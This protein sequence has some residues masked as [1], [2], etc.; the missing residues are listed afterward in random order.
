MAVKYRYRYWD[1]DGHVYD[2]VI[3]K[4]RQTLKWDMRGFTERNIDWQELIEE[5]MLPGD[6]RL[7]TGMQ[8]WMRYQPGEKSL[9][10]DS[11][12]WDNIY[13]WRHDGTTY[14]SDWDQRLTALAEQAGVPS[15]NLIKMWPLDESK[16]DAEA[17]TKGWTKLTCQQPALASYRKDDV[18]LN[19]YLSTGTVGSCLDHP[20]KGKT[21]LFRKYMENPMS[22]FDNPREHTGKGYYTK[23]EG[24]VSGQKRKAQHGESR[25][26]SCASCKQD[27]PIDQFS[28]NQQRKG[29]NARCKSCVQ[30]TT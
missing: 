28:K 2:T 23:N 8:L 21:Q 24:S 14:C 5:G 26:R 1:N 11:E 20:T 15:D 22:L 16:L 17:S 30:A 6:F 29:Q 12:F 7:N 4:C 18:R 25:T 19:F 9:I 27:Q 10:N 13:A 3:A